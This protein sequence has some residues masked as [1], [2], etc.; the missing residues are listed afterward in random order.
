MVEAL[1]EEKEATVNTFLK[2]QEDFSEKN[3]LWMALRKYECWVW[4]SDT[5]MCHKNWKDDSPSD[6]GGKSLAFL[7]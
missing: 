6:S 4:N 2:T 1:S 3:C 7:S 5:P